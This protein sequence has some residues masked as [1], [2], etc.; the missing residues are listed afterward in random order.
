[1]TTNNSRGYSSQFIRQ[2]NEADPALLGVRLA[3]VCIKQEIPATA[4]AERVGVS[5]Q[6]VY[7]WFV[8]RFHPRAEQAERLADLLERYSAGK[9]A[10]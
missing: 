2:V 10:R 8:G 3:K 4:V 6:T 9:L 1:M 7:A 5:R